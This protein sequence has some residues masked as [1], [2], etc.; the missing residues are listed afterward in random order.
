MTSQESSAV[1]ERVGI[2]E[3][4]L[5]RMLVLILKFHQ[6]PLVTCPNMRRFV[7]ELAIC[8]MR[9]KD[10]NVQHFKDLGMEKE[11]EHVVET[12]SLTG[13]KTEKDC[14]YKRPPTKVI[15]L[16]HGGE[17]V[18]VQNGTNSA[19]DGQTNTT[20]RK[21][22][23]SIVGGLNVDVGGHRWAELAVVD[24]W[25][26]SAGVG[27]RNSVGGGGSG[28][29]AWW[30]PVAEKWVSPEGVTVGNPWI[31]WIAVGVCGWSWVG[32]KGGLWGRS[33]R[34]WW[35]VVMGRV[36]ASGVL[37]AI[38]PAVKPRRVIPTRIADSVA[39]R[40][41]LPCFCWK[42]KPENCRRRWSQDER[43]RREF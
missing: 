13:L 3:A 37:T 28:F 26:P 16:T 5:A 42:G 8:L 33:G 40:V 19:F 31:N 36:A 41:S 1:L 23:P 30:L 6:Y 27:G 35:V 17:T 14:Q 24:C 38:L 18:K 12:T 9:D 7:V 22:R 34:R 10:K 4:E 21:K 39:V 43:L 11:L 32:E 15:E 20:R 29:W 25:W 2:Q